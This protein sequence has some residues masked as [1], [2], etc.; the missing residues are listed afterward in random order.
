VATEPFLPESTSARTFPEDASRRSGSLFRTQTIQRLNILRDSALC[1]GL[2]DAEIT[3]LA[4]LARS[5]IFERRDVIFAQG[6]PVRQLLLL[7]SGS[8]KLTQ[9]GT[10]GS[11]V[12]LWLR[13]AGDPVGLTGA[14]SHSPHTCS[15]R[16][17]VTCRA[18]V[19]DWS[20]LESAYRGTPQIRR[21]MG[22]ILSERLS[23]LEERF[24]EIATEKV[25]R[26]VAFALLRIVKQVGKNTPSGIEIFLSREE[27]AQLTGT[28][29]F[30]ISRLMSR[31]S[32]LGIVVPRREAVLILD[33]DRLAMAGEE[34]E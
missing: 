4:G 30:S 23:E 34:N 22:G 9:V 3:E 18:M 1:A 15:A 29:L 27:I 24:R 6:Q 16:V 13:G 26:R 20:K 28:T 21:N 5:K 19:W 32:E 10:N 25:A 31:W 14:L 17:V 7:E 11:E 33:V 2:T 12:I 8:V